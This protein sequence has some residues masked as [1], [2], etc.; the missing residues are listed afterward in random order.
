MRN[1]GA[2]AKRYKAHPGNVNFR[3]AQIRSRV[4]R[5]VAEFNRHDQFGELLTDMRF[6]MD[7]VALGGQGRGAQDDIADGGL[8]AG[9]GM[10]V[11]QGEQQSQHAAIEV[12]ARQEDPFPGHEAVFENQVRVGQPRRESPFKVLAL[13]VIVNG[14]HLLHAVVVRR[15]GKRHGVVLVFLAQR[16]GGNDQDF[17]GDGGFRNVQFAPFYNDAVLGSLLDAHVSA[18]I[19]LFGWAQHAVALGVRLGAGGNHVFLLESGQPFL[20][21]LVV[22]GLARPDLVRLVRNIV[23]GVGAV[24]AHTPLNAAA[25]FLAEHAGHVLLAVQ[26]GRVLVNVREAVD[27]LSGEVRRG[28]HQRF[29]LRLG[30]LVIGRAHDVDAVA[31]QLVG[32]VDQL[33]VIIDVAFHL[34]QGVDKILLGSHGGGYSFLWVCFFSCFLCFCGKRLRSPPEIEAPDRFAA[35]ARERGHPPDS[36]AA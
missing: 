8:A 19:G 31:L 30:G 15:H 1:V 6:L 34:R 16:A 13:T 33:P 23:D 5:R 18:R 32:A 4:A 24:D 21:V 9:V 22:I 29:V 28:R 20:E 10:A 11:E 17:I 25:D 12:L 27:L 3:F 26:I 14:H 2:G 35:S 36:N 7:V